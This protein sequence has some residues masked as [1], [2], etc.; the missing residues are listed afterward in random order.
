MARQWGLRAVKERKFVEIDVRHGGR[1]T[2]RIIAEIRNERWLKPEEEDAAKDILFSMASEH[3]WILRDREIGGWGETA[4][5]PI[6]RLD[7]LV[8]DD[9]LGLKVWDIV[10]A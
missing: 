1:V 2:H 10:T 6:P 3:N 9:V 5:R 7:C 4:H 8:A